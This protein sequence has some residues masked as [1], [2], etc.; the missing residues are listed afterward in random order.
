MR[1]LAER[2]GV[3]LAMIYE[4]W[5]KDKVPAEWRVLGRLKLGHPMVVLGGNL[6]TFYATDAASWAKATAALPDFVRSLPEGVAF[7]AP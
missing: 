1:G 4:P 5:F 2:H 7:L 6:V 3:G